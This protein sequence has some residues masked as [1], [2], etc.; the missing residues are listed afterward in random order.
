MDN[1][2][3]EEIFDSIKKLLILNYKDEK[4]NISKIIEDEQFYFIKGKKALEYLEDKYKPETDIEKLEK[5][6]KC[7]KEQGYENFK[8]NSEF[9]EL[10]NDINRF[11]AYCDLN[12]KGTYTVN[13]G[14]KVVEEYSYYDDDI[15]EDGNV[16]K[17]KF[18]KS[19][20]DKRTI[21]K[22]YVYQ[23]DWIKNI[24]CFLIN[25][26]D[27]NHI[28][29]DSVKRAI[30][31]FKEPANNFTTLSTEHREYIAKYF[32]IYNDDNFDENLKKK[33]DDNLLET[34]NKL[35]KDKTD[36]NS[37]E[38]CQDNL[39]YIY[40]ELIYKIDSEWK[41]FDTSFYEKNW[42]V[43][44]TGAPGTGKTFLAK[45]IAASIIGCSVEELEKGKKEQF[46]FVQFHPSY[47]YTD[48]VEG[49]RPNYDTKTNSNL[50]FVLQFGTFKEFCK[51]AAISF[52]NKEEKKFVFIID[53]I[54][55]GEISKIFG[56]LF[57]AI[58]PGYREEKNRILVKT[59]YQNL[60]RPEI[61]GNNNPFTEGF[62]VPENVYIIGTMN[63]IDRSVESMDFAFRRRFAF[64][65]IKAKESQD[66]ILF[67]D[68][69][70][71][72]RTLVT[73][74]KAMDA[75]NDKL[76]ILGLND[77]YHI[78]AAYFK[79]IGL[80]SRQKTNK[81]NSLWEHHLYGT[82]FEYF[83]GEPDALDKMKELEKVY[84]AV[85]NP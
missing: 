59:Q 51:T 20:I 49:L 73:L 18:D 68:K 27:T 15:Q 33:F 16:V 29:N 64:K 60:N 32:N 34:I 85:V 78:G 80:Y 38:I 77:S 63:D 62:Y 31:Y 5:A 76:T 84:S 42:N 24:L 26:K 39:T 37:R 47:D 44:L 81:W 58:D 67:Y 22:A 41:P 14:E 74:I 3:I 1:K 36:N 13:E 52:N 46:G 35:L 70:I 4:T 19:K 43:I 54:N 40:T 65:E 25:N 9:I 82:L 7:L 61:T 71:D 21:A 45:K 72:E 10:C 12:A 66:N 50:S 6:E 2:R 11:V 8:N 23:D 83:R 57:F 30:K 56:E 48:F 75:I 28:E 17:K 79:K 55:R 53:E 69:N